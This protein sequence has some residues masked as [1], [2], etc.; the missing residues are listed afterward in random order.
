MNL[1][2]VIADGIHRYRA[3]HSA[4]FGKLT[5]P[6]TSQ[7]SDRADAEAQPSFKTVA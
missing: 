6:K 5:K 4:I 3:Y 1:C 2:Y 7:V